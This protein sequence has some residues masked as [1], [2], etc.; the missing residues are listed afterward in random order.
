MSLPSTTTWTGELSAR[1]AGALSN[2]VAKA[3][4]ATS[5]TAD[6]PR[7]V[8]IIFRQLLCVNEQEGAA[9]SP[10][11]AAA[12]AAAA[13]RFP[14]GR[15]PRLQT[16]GVPLRPIHEVVTVDRSRSSPVGSP[17][18]GSPRVY[19]GSPLQTSLTSTT[20]PSAKAKHPPGRKRA[21]SSCARRPSP[22]PTTAA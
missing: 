6:L 12:T 7:V 22:S 14:T 20:L 15:M 2:P 8:G 16:L 10:A 13:G 3:V 11:P 9:E 1:A 4:A 5:R 18:L 21:P 17:H 19:S